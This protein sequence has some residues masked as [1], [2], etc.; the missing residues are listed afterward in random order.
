VLVPVMLRAADS[1]STRAQE[2]TL[3]ALQVGIG[4]ALERLSVACNLA[5]E[6][7]SSHTRA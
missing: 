3:K 5:G 4:T 1:N 6:E 2:E 7:Q